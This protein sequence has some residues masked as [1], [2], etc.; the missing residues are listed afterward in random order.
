MNNKLLLQAMAVDLKRV[1]IGYHSGSVR[2]ADRFLQEVMQRIELLQYS[3]LSSS[4]KKL[5]KK[6]E[7]LPKEKNIDKRAEDA[8]LYSTLFLSF[9]K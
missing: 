2:M 8:L 9:S 4:M 7:K 3:S 6:I 5:L 1:A